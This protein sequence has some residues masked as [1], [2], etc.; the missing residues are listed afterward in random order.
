[1]YSDCNESQL[2]QGSDVKT[3]LEFDL[4]SCTVEERREVILF[5]RAEK[6]EWDEA[7]PF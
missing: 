2:C 1:M 6:A 5:L 4:L 3:E 7:L